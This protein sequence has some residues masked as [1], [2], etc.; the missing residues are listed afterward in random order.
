MILDGNKIGFGSIFCGFSTLTVN[1]TIGA[2]FHANVYSCVA[3]DCVVG[4]FVTLAPG[5]KI[6]GN[7]VLEDDSYIGTGAII[8][9]G[10]P[11][12]PIVIGRGAVVGMGAID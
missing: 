7:V 4:D 6:N 10:N 2:C 8:K 9:H 1:S 3:H 12:D 5:C 11:E